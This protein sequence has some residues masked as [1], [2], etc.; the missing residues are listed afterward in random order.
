MPQGDPVAP[1]LFNLSIEPLFNALRSS[2]LWIR[3]YADDT[4][5]IGFD[6]HAWQPLYFWLYQYNLSAG[7]EVHWGKTTLLPLSP[8]TYTPPHNTPN[9]ATLPLSTLGVLLPLSWAN[10]DTLWDTLIRKL[11]SRVDSLYT[12]SLSL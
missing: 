1:I 12:R 5:A 11:S 8:T 10:I 9:P 4:Y 6:E 3:A 2:Q 7:G